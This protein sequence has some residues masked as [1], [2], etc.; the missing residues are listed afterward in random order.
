MQPPLGKLLAKIQKKTKNIAL[1]LPTETD[2]VE[3]HKIA[4]SS[5]YEIENCYLDDEL[6][7]YMIYFGDLAPFLKRNFHFC[8]SALD[9]ESRP[10]VNW[11]PAFA[12]MTRL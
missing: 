5:Y 9:A 3:F 4:G 1:R 11:V 12:V 10:L 6:K 8:H 7:F 2:L